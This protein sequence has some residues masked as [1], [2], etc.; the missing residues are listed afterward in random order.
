LKSGYCFETPQLNMGACVSLC[1]FILTTLINFYHPQINPFDE[2]Y[3]LLASLLK[4]FRPPDTEMIDGP[5]GLENE[6]DEEASSLFSV[7]FS[8]RVRA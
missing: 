5:V 7:S 1:R 8:I 4:T 6:N 2:I 3:D